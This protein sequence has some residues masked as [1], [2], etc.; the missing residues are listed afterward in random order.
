[1]NVLIVDDHPVYRDG[2][3][4]LLVQLFADAHVTQASDVQKMFEVLEQ[5]PRIDM[6]LLDLGLPAVGG[7]AALPQLRVR[8]PAIP[9]VVISATDDSAVADACMAQGASGFIPKSVRREALAAA[10][11]AVL[12]GD[13]YLA[14]TFRHGAQRP[15][16]STL[17]RREIEVL[18]RMGAGEPNKVIARHLGISEATVRAHCSAVFRSFGVS[19]R[20]QAIAE[21]NRRGLLDTAI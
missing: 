12:D 14:P 21:A 2:L 16:L 20:T 18:R 17:T 13:V 19:S 11:Q 8:F 10:L 15:A 9:V 5:D 4:A 3:A 6:L 1:M 7:S